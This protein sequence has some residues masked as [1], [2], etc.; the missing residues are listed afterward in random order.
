MRR[1][2]IMLV[3]LTLLAASATASAQASPRPCTIT[4]TAGDDVLNGTSAG[5]VICGLGGD[6]RIRGGGGDDVLRGGPGHDALRGDGGRDRLIGG[7][8]GDI[9]IDDDRDTV[10]SGRDD[11]VRPL[12]DRLMTG[13]VEFRGMSGITVTLTQ[14][15]PTNCTRDEGYETF[16]IGSDPVI[17]WL[18]ATVKSSGSCWFD[19]SKNTWHAQFSDGST[20]DLSMQTGMGIE[21]PEMWCGSSDWRG[22][23]DCRGTN[24]PLGAN[25][26]ERLIVKPAG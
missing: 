16:Q 25:T 21:Q 17:Y 15:A 19:W 1:A 11:D 5:D 26:S 7:A 10:V 18:V 24:R 8:A 12:G 4:G 14:G 20:G 13:S 9:L 6:D 23:F 22:A 3:A 2:T